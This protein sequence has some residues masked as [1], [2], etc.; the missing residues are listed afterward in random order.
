M[1]SFLKKNKKYKKYKK[2][3]NKKTQKFKKK[4]KNYKNKKTQEFKKFKNY[5]KYKNKKTIKSKTKKKKTDILSNYKTTVKKYN[6]KKALVNE[7]RMEDINHRRIYTEYNGINRCC[8]VN[9]KTGKRCKNQ[10]VGF[11][12]IKDIVNPNIKKYT[13]VVQCKKHEKI[14]KKKYL[15]YKKISDKLYTYKTRDIFKNHN[16]CKNKNE[17]EKNKILKNINNV[18]W[19]RIN[20]PLNCSYGCLV[21]PNGSEGYKLMKKKEDYHFHEIYHLIKN[22][23]A[24]KKL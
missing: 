15:N 12:I 22:K 2:Y 17:K 7:R 4:Y 23:I 20:Y 13:F 14:C 19:K 18:I 8:Y 5:K 3:K 24:C 11:K 10:C 9:N 1:K 21:Y 6:Y 16:L